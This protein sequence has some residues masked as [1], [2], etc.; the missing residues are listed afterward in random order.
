MAELLGCAAP[1]AAAT[2]SQ[3]C[4]QGSALYDLERREYRHRELFVD[5]AAVFRRRGILLP[6]HRQSSQGTK[7]SREAMGPEP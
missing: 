1:D 5:H 7:R 3:V 6:S 2:L 4:R